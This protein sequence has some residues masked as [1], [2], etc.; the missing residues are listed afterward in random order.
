MRSWLA[1]VATALVLALCVGSTSAAPDPTPA[2]PPECPSTLVC[3]TI[4]EAAALKQEL[5]AREAEI[6]RLRASSSHRKL[7]PYATAWVSKLYSGSE[8]GE[9]ALGGSLGVMLFDSISLSFGVHEAYGNTG[10][11]LSAAYTWRF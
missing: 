5:L 2:P 7:S 9:V 1:L 8:E 10:L 4:D 3:L 11:G 6:A